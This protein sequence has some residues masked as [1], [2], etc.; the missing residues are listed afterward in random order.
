MKC[1]NC[2]CLEDKVIDSRLSEDGVSIRRRRE[3][4]AC[5]KRF[6]TYETIETLPIYIVK[7]TGVREPFDINKIKTGILKA[8]EKRPVP[9]TEIEKK[10]TNSLQQEITSHEIGNMVMAG[11]KKIDDVAYVRFS[12]LYKEFKDLESWFQEMESYL[13]ERK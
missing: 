7:K 4:V 11:L 9:I 1:P 6:T 13:N 8:C 5:G 12:V 10:V 3:C 2:N